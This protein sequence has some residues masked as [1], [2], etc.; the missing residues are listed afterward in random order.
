[1]PTRYRHGKPSNI[2]DLLVV[3]KPEIVQDIAYSNNLGASDHVAISVSLYCS[4]GL[5]TYD[6][7]KRNY[8]KGNFDSIRMDLNRVK[9]DQIHSM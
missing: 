4:L 8:H 7:L 3:D 2:L 9:W 6:S 1:M 5:I